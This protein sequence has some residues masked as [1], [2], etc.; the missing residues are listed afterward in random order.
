M[1]IGIIGSGIVG[2]TL[3]VGF[4]SN[5]HQV[6]IG[7]RTHGKLAEWLAT[8][9]PNVTEGSF[10]DA[11]AAGE[12]VILSVNAEN[13]ASAVEAAGRDALDGKIVID[14]SNP[15]DFSQGIPPRFTATVGDSLG[16]RVQRLLPRSSVVKAFN[17]MGFS[18]MT[19][20]LFDGEAGTHFIAGNDDGAKSVV[21]N[22]LEE[23]GWEVLDVGG[24]EQAF[25]LEALASLWV[26]YSFRSGQREQAFK[27]LTR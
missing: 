16:E 13:L 23:F 2:K 3:A 10:A 24:I 15:M 5:G 27:L 1:K 25:F 14:V 8:A 22:L 4:A 7:T 9:G 17:S 19:E 26:N 20:P 18:V 12:V 11:A 21:S 6:V